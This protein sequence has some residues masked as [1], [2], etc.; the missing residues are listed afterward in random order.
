MGRRRGCAWNW[1]RCATCV[2]AEALRQEDLDRFPHQLIPPVPEDL[3]GL[4]VRK[5]D[6]AAPIDGDDGVRG[7]LD[8]GTEARF[9]RP[10]LLEGHPRIAP[11]KRA[12]PRGDEGEARARGHAPEPCKEAPEG[13]AGRR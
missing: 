7:R 6:A 12:H 1:R 10:D 2:L 8:Q 9:L 5:H 13:R 3:L 4:G 11:A